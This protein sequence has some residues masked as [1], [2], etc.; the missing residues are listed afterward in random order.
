MAP[1]GVI[2]AVPDQKPRANAT[3]VEKVVP[4]RIKGVLVEYR[5]ASDPG[6]LHALRFGRNKIGRDPG[7]DVCLEEPRASQD[8]AYIY[9]RE[10]GAVY[11]DTSRNGSKVQGEIVWGSQAGL[12]MGSIIE[13]GETT[14]VLLLVPERAEVDRT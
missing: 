8:H 9:L 4:D 7:S 10:Q 6:R 1:P 12:E 2:S 14:L 13:I 5:V 11:Q 3:I